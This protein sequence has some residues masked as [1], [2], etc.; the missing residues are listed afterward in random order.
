MKQLDLHNPIGTESRLYF[1]ELL[2]TQDVQRALEQDSECR[3]YALKP[4]PL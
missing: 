2:I 1:K 4:G 3:T